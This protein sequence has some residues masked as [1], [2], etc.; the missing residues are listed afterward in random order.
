M[1]SHLYPPPPQDPGSN[2]TGTSRAR[3]V[4]TSFI[5][6]VEHRR[7]AE[8][9]ESCRRFRYIGLC[10]GPPGTGKTLSSRRLSDMDRVEQQDPWSGEPVFGLPIATAFYTASVL[11]T[12]SQVAA[13]IRSAT[14]KLSILARGPMNRRFEIALDTVRLRNENY[15][16]AHAAHLGSRLFEEPPLEPTYAQVLAA[17]EAEKKAIGS[18][19]TLLIIDEADRLRISSLEQVRALFDESRFGLILVGMP[20]LEKRMARYPQLYSRIGFVHPYRALAAEEMRRL[21]DR[22]WAPAGVQLPDWGWEEAAV[23]AAIR[24]TGGNF[25]LFGRL[26]AQLE[27]VLAINSLGVVTREAVEA[28][29]ESLVVGSA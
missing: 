29:R 7:F 22:R 26:L 27:R 19:T 24:S 6:T 17:F 13:G 1:A 8:F 5:E 28:A 25:R 23:A 20:G 12:P 14:E 16:R 2:A 3:D 10:Y 15:R 11:N 21:I 18:P 9:A 4:E